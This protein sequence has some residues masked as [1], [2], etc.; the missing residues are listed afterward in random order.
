MA[1]FYGNI[2]YAEMIETR[3]GVWE[4]Q[5][6]D[7]PYRG[8]LIRNTR[9]LQSSDKLHDNIVIANEI[10]IIA[11]PFANQ[12][13]HSIRYVEFNGAKWKVDNVEVQHPRLILTLGGLYNDGE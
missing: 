11:D 3:P 4:E 2:G 7:H 12:N 5:I 8:E 9:R 6:T 1:K 10:S 13:F